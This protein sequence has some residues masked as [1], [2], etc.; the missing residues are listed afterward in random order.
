L[1]PADYRVERYSTIDLSLKNPL[2]E[3]TFCVQRST[4]PDTRD[5]ITLITDAGG[6]VE[7]DILSPEKIDF[8]VWGK[9]SLFLT[10]FPIL[11]FDFLSFWSGDIDDLKFW[12]RSKRI[13]KGTSDTLGVLKLEELSTTRKIEIVTSKVR[14]LKSRIL[15]S[16]FYVSFLP[17][18]VVYL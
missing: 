2:Q 14:S 7:T 5:L 6:T 18:F 13:K 8:V 10:T 17:F 11:W 3:Y 16:L 9:L 4:V 1:N 12:I 15:Y